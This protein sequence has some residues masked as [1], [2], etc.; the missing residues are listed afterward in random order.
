MKYS[1]REKL[2]SIIS[3]EAYNDSEIALRLIHLINQLDLHEPVNKQGK[4]I[5]DLYENACED[6]KA[7]R[8]NENYIKTGYSHFD[9]TIRGFLPGEFVVIGGRPGMGKTQFA[10]NLA[11]NI[12]KSHNTQFYTYDDTEVNI[13]RRILGNICQIPVH[14]FEYD[15]LTDDDKLK[16]N[17]ATDL[18]KSLK[19]HISECNYLNFLDFKA[20]LIKDIKEKELKVVFIDFLQAIIP[21]KTRYNREFEIGYVCR[22]LKA[23][24]KEYNVC[25]ITTCQL[26]RAVETRGTS[27]R[28]QLSDLRDSGSIEQEADKVLMLYRPEYYQLDTLEDGTSTLG[29]M[30]VSVVKNRSGRLDETRLRCHLALCFITEYNYFEDD[31]D[32][33]E[34]RLLDINKLNLL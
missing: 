18:I 12:S 26:S 21:S 15:E 30:E 34:T 3:N 14:K 11:I 24:A 28:P 27:K 20:D 23:I 13:T 16:V 31:F 9:R 29:L 10:L 17:K 6:I 1:L 8:A 25:I 19:L 32:F 7:N 5:G 4:S 22:E 33:N 2:E